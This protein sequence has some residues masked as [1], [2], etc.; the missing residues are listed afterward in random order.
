MADEIRQGTVLQRLYLWACE[1]L[2]AEFAWSYD[3]VSWLVSFGAWSHWQLAVL[4][5]IRGERV[6]EIGFGTGTLLATLAQ[7]G[8]QV[9]GL[10]RSVA[11][12][13]QTDRK[14]VRVALTIDRVQAPT[15]QMP[16]Q[17]NRFDTIVSTF[18]S[19]YIFDPA[20]L[21]ECA[22]ILRRATPERPGGRLVILMSVTNDRTPWQA[23][24]QLLTWSQRRANA[25]GTA[26][27]GS[28]TE[29]ATL[30]GGSLHDRF[31]GAG[32]NIIQTTVQAEGATL[33]LL[34]AK[35]QTET[36]PCC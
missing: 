27:S 26:R 28:R 20:T 15:Q 17:A 1:R 29:G 25:R 30:Q 16:F 32:L 2:Y 10:E 24:M 31:A 4:P 33:H 3:W 23:I 11:M 21:A 9:T 8:Y 19:D 12:H 14:L 36:V 22:R 6:L 34:L 35:H 7:H 18:P 5:Y 13:H